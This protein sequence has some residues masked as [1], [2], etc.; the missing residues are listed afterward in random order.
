MDALLI[1][2]LL[3][4]VSQAC[5]MP[6]ASTDDNASSAETALYQTN[7]L[8][9]SALDL[10]L[11]G[12]GNRILNH[13]TGSCTLETLR[14]RRDWRALTHG[15]RRSYIDAILCLQQLSPQ[16]PAALAA[17]AKTRYDDFLATHINQTW[18][19]HRTVSVVNPR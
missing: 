15:E 5:A 7:R 14:V 10:T 12:L 17:G 8:A 13:D 19:I 1:S 18:H 11:Y 9:R 16:T 6:M 3:C 2:F 4:L